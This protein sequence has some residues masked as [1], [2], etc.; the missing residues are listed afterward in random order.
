MAYNSLQ[1]QASSIMLQAYLQ[2]LNIK[3]RFGYP[4]WSRRFRPSF[5]LSCDIGWLL[6]G[7][8][9]LC[10]ME[11]GNSW[12][13]YSRWSTK[14]IIRH[15]KFESVVIQTVNMRFRACGKWTPGLFAYSSCHY[16]HSVSLSALFSWFVM[17]PTAPYTTITM[18]FRGTVK[19][20]TT[21]L[22]WMFIRCGKE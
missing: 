6:V 1:L 2:T 8:L 16:P 3:I 15:P 17:E 12:M 19:I 13:N 21:V 22:C 14:S 4:P 5:L 9:S 7:F 10:R 18:D 11:S 20:S